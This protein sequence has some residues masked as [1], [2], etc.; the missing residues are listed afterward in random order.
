MGS[1]LGGTHASNPGTNRFQWRAEEAHT[2]GA[3]AD[4]TLVV[5]D[6]DCT[7]AATHMYAL[8]RSGG[9]EWLERDPDNFYE[10]V[11]GGSQRVIELQTF[12]TNLRSSGATLYVLSNG[13][14]AEIKPALKSVQ[15][16]EAF[17]RWR[18]PPNDNKA[19]PLRCLTLSLAR[20]QGR[21]R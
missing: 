6:F 15:L 10:R 13:F 5:L 21:R 19:R 12:L 7:I 1:A 9:Q 14:E 20:W 3:A 16:L 8:L 18:C 17:E 4:S 2:G 11:F